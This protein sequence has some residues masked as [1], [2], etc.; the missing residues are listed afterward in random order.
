[1][2]AR[3]AEAPDFDHCL[4]A[5][6][7]SPAINHLDF[8]DGSALSFEVEWPGAGAFADFR[9][10]LQVVNLTVRIDYFEVHDMDVVTAHAQLN[11]TETPLFAANADGVA[12]DG[13]ANA[14]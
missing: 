14:L 3:S 5:E 11:G 9:A 4:A 2:S 6:I 8:T 1:M 12:V 13:E 10:N 7:C